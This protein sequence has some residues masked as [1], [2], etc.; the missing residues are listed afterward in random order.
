MS[1]PTPPLPR[2]TTA[3]ISG[4][5]YGYQLES[6]TRLGCGFSQVVKHVCDVAI[7]DTLQLGVVSFE[8]AHRL[9]CAMCQ[10]LARFWRESKLRF[11]TKRLVVLNLF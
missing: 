5:A 3:T 2:Y 9:R 8:A 6:K 11:I 4:G 10:I 7:T 1:L